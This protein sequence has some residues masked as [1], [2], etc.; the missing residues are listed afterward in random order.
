MEGKF[1]NLGRNTYFDCCNF[2][3]QIYCNP[4]FANSIELSASVVTSASVASVVVV[5]CT[6]KEHRISFQIEAN[7]DQGCQDAKD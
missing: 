5:L 6:T 3:Y 2:F 4:R 7:I 1:L